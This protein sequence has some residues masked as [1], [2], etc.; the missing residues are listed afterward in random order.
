VM[1]HDGKGNGNP[2]CIDFSHPHEFLIIPPETS[3]IPARK[4]T[5]KVCAIR[6]AYRLAMCGEAP[7]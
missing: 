6:E 1:W 7:T 5:G 3:E 4:A 2:A